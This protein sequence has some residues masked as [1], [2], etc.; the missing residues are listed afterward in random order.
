MASREPAMHCVDCG[1]TH[2]R[3]AALQPSPFHS[4]MA[5]EKM[6]NAS[7]TTAIRDF[8]RDIDAEMAWREETIKRLRCEVAELRRRSDHHKAI[9]APIRRIPPET[10]AEIFLQLTAME[11]TLKETPK[12]I[13][14]EF[15]Y[16]F[17][18]CYRVRPLIHKAPLLFCEISRTWR[19][20]ALSIPML[21]NSLSLSSRDQKLVT[22][23]LL[24][25]TWLKRSGSLPL[26]IRLYPRPYPYS[27]GRQDSDDLVKTILPFAARWQALEVD[28][29]SA[30][31]HTLLRHIFSDP[32]PILETLS[33]S[34]GQQIA[35]WEG[36]RV[37][38]PKLRR[39]HLKRIGG[40]GII[41]QREQATFPWSQLT[42]I[43]L[44]DCSSDDCLQ[45]LHQ[46]SAALECRFNVTRSFS[47]QAHHPSIVLS[48]LH[49]L[50]IHVDNHATLGPW[51]SHLTC[52]ALSTLVVD[53]DTL[54]QALPSFITRTGKTI[55]DFSLV[56]SGLD[57]DH[58][59][60]CL[61]DMPLLRR[62][63]VSDAELGRL[64]TNEVWESFTWAAGR[65][66]TPPL[67]PKLE[68]LDVTGGMHCNHKYIVRMLK[69]RL[70][71][72]APELK[73][74]KLS[75]WRNLSSSAYSKLSA[76]GELGLKMTIEHLE[77]RYDD[78][79]GSEASDTE[80]GTGGESGELQGL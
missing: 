72:T 48:E 41:T 3:R 35:T 14:E 56:R 70:R 7:E 80:D 67:I 20:I 37:D 66:S 58:F 1:E 64:M 34:Y 32:V 74:V 46:A 55:E 54:S 27:L 16:L 36:V 57:D 18:S 53:S 63:K 2:Y 31:S 4:L 8:I 11:K 22:G 73:V 71:R 24:C 45:I 40:A 30:S 61:A 9:I 79:N 77:F 76:F 33:V 26:S 75:L 62:L 39:L 51:W 68:S 43:D 65:D 60:A 21:W 42:H 15:P 5:Q 59:M 12:E 10:M 50:R 47:P 6:P 13:N 23:A 19:A 78:E 49:A 25:D 28:G 38:A 29:L 69:S 44:G 52:P 17:N